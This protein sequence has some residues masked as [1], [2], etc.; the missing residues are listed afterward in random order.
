[1]SLGGQAPVAD[2][3]SVVFISKC[4]H[5]GEQVRVNMLAETR[6]R[7]LC[8]NCA[9]KAYPEAFNLAAAQV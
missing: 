7:V 1:M 8:D 9:A 6:M 4:A 3:H 2:T 5:C